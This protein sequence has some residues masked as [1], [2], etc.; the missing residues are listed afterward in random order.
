M[1]TE[2]TYTAEFRS[3]FRATLTVSFK[4]FRCEWTPDLPRN[5]PPAERDAL[6]ESYRAWRDGCLAEFAEANN[7]TVHA[8]RQDGLDCI[9]FKRREVSA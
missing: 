3:G 2:A 9:A 1:S 7:L 8:I 4:G 6:I 5:L